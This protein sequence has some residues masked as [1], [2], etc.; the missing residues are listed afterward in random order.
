M[1]LNP[2]SV[3]KF[4]TYN[5]C[6]QKF[7]LKYIQKVKVPFSNS[8]ALFK[9][10]FIHEVLENKFNYDIEFETNELFTEEEKEKT[11]LII[12]KFEESELGQKYKKIIN[13]AVLEEDFAFKIV[14]SELVLCDFWDKD[15]WCRGSAD[16]Y[17]KRLASAYIWDYKSGK[18][19]SEDET[20]GIDQ[21]MMYAIYMFLKF[22]DVQT[23]KAIFCFVEHRTEK[24]L[25]YTRDKL[26][27]YVQFFYNNTKTVENDEFYDA[28]IGPLCDYCDFYN[29]NVCTAPTEAA[30]EVE[31][32]MS[33]A[34]SLDF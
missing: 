22:P 19:K 18:D 24:E 34:I 33:S 14:D 29:H 7:D 5:Q 1:T 12:K 26:A 3:S 6:P 8:I 17:L 27:E 9:G 11:K 30:K 32:L 15:A 13:I 23:V 31:S 21:S 4:G 20:F 16:L 28:K 2:F 25:V 10:S